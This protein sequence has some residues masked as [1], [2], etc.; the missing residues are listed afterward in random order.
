MT[1]FGFRISGLVA[2]STLFL[3]G[4]SYSLFGEKEQASSG[5]K[6]GTPYK[7]DGQY[8]YPEENYDLVETG[9]ASWYGPNFHGKKTANGETFDENKL[10]AAHRTLQLPSVARVTNLQNGKS[11][12]VRVNDRGPF[13]KGRVLDV[14]KRAAEELGFKNQGTTT[15]RIEVLAEQSRQAAKL[16]GGNPASGV[17]RSARSLVTPPENW[18]SPP[19]SLARN[20]SSATPSSS[21]GDIYVQAG[22]FSVRENAYKLRDQLSGMGRASVSESLVNGKPF[23]RV[24]FGPLSSRQQAD[25]VI[26]QLNEIGNRDAV[27]VVD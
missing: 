14:S 21:F 5:F 22:A 12:I 9:K 2:L 7:I 11:V 25:G 8:Y 4:C 23:Y 1:L 16:S 26:G 3:G 27:V 20:V 13:S 18:S 24:R 19:V 6:V 10:T 17:S 15:V